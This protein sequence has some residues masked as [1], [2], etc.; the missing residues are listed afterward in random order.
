MSPVHLSRMILF[1]RWNWTDL[2][3]VSIMIT[4][5]RGLFRWV[6][7]WERRESG[8][9]EGRGVG[10]REV[11]LEEERQGRERSRREGGKEECYS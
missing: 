2:G 11:W 8:S 9:A 3:S 10:G 1:S 4:L 7:S 6:R 5:L